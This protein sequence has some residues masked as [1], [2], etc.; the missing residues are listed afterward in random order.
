MLVI[1]NGY[2]VTLDEKDTLYD[3]GDVI[4][5]GDRITYVG[6]PIESPPE[7]SEVIDAEG[8]L[9]MP[10]LVNV[11]CHSNELLNRGRFDNMPLEVWGLY[12]YPPLDYGPFPHRLLY[13]RTILGA[14]EMLRS[15]FTAVQDD[16]AEAPRMTLEG[17]GAVRQAYADIGMRANVACNQINKTHFDQYPGLREHMPPGLVERMTSR[18]PLAIGEIMAVYRQIVERWHNVADGR[19]RVTLAFSAPQRCTSDYL[20][21]I[22]ALSEEYDL[23]LHMHILE[24]KLQRVNS[25][26]LYGMTLVEY[27]DSLGL[28][29]PRS[30]VIHSIWVE[31]RDI[32]R[33]GERGVCV[34]HCPIAN[35]RLGDGIMPLRRLVEAGVTVG[36]GT[37][38]P[39]SNDSLNAFELLKWTAIIHKNTSPD[40]S[41]WPTAREVLG[42]A[43]INGARSMMLEDDVGRLTPGRKADLILLDL[44]APSF[45]PLNNVYNQLVYSEN[46]AAVET[47]VVNGKVIMRDRRILTF[48]E[49]E[50]FKELTDLMPEQNTQIER[51]REV[52]E[53]FAPFYEEHY[54]QAAAAE[55]GIDRWATPI[56]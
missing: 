12:A 32:E 20:L 34:A 48:D 18:A 38:G 35:L 30:T 41:L 28:L 54:Q 49:A 45:M 31:D 25:R 17:T 10:G 6:P 23:P 40:T 37:D 24:T 44:H 50:L 51:A 26:R 42:M 43:T 11:H 27:A 33:M 46:G 13:L 2:V 1:R 22:N 47:S 53:K 9:V 8:K 39:S 16:V 56:G 5:E 4:I 55:V 19:L 3:R 29:T 7:E 52:S 14:I 21:S 15:G 36:L